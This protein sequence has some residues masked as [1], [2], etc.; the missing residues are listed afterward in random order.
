MCHCDA[1]RMKVSD[2]KLS[3]LGRHGRIVPKGSLQWTTR[4]LT[5]VAPYNSHESVPAIDTHVDMLEQLAILDRLVL[6]ASIT[7]ELEHEC[8]H[9][10]V[11]VL[12][13]ICWNDDMSATP[14]FCSMRSAHGI[15]H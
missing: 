1:I 11:V 2:E 3:G 15:A 14:F 13:R 7:L 6:I 4:I 8:L 5:P 9:V 12:E 10:L